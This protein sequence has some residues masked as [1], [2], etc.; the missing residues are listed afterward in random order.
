MH[1]PAAVDETEA[2]EAGSKSGA[3]V[4]TSENNLDQSKG[5]QVER[6]GRDCMK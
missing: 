3:S 1:Q 4:H 6:K 2:S 5:K